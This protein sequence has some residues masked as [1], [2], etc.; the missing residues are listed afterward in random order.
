MPEG[1]K[2]WVKPEL[3]VLVRSNP[4]EWVLL[5]CKGNNMNS[6]SSA[7]RSWCGG[8]DG[9]VCVPQCDLFGPS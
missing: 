4:E 8:W 3:I 1:K 9:K 7:G 2:A 5:S 6:S